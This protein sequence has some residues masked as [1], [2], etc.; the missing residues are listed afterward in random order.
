MLGDQDT[1]T[2]NYCDGGPAISNCTR[3][4]HKENESLKALNCH[5]NIWSEDERSSVMALRQFLILYRNKM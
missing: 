1:A 3:K 4:L 2:T 5:L